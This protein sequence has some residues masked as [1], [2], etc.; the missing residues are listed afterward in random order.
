MTALI[1]MQPNP[2]AETF[3]PLFPS[4]RICIVL[5]F[6]LDCSCS[7]E[8][9]NSDPFCSSIMLPGDRPVFIGTGGIDHQMPIGGQLVDS[10]Q[11]FA[12][13]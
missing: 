7:S 1:L 2:I 8:G 11:V 5:S 3:R 13:E 9:A 12:D 10:R 4:V 6:I